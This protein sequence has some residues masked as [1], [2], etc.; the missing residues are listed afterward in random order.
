M[1]H[2]LFDLLAAA[3]S[4]V[5]TWLIFS[6]GLRDRTEPLARGGMGYAFA[7][8]AGAAV[9]GYALGSLNLVLSGEPGIGRSILGALGGAI[10]GVEVFKRAKGIRGSTG[11]VLVPAFCTTVV[12]GRI[13]CFLSGIRD[14]TYGVATQL[15]WGHDFGDGIL[16]H[17]VQLYESAAM[18]VFLFVALA[19]LRARRPF[20]LRNGFYL[21]VGWY[22][23]QRYAWEFLKPYGTVLTGQNVFHLISLCLIAYALVMMRGAQREGVQYA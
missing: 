21:M 17:P 11:L 15:P 2:T 18:T 3:S 9:G 6:G 14:F 8:I 13:G 7:L 4:L 19:L 10:F 12:I 23:L 20:F 16:R 5:V 22:S 1:V